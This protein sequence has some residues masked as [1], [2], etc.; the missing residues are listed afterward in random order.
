MKFSTVSTLFL[1]QGII[2]MPWFSAKS[3]AAG[4]EITMPRTRIATVTIAR[5]AERTSGPVG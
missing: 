2:A 4:D 1:T 3:K 5:L